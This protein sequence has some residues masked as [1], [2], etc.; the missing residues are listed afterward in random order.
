MRVSSN[1]KAEIM[2][3]FV[4]CRSSVDNNITH[5]T[6]SSYSQLANIGD[7]KGADDGQ[8]NVKS[9]RKRTPPFKII[10]KYCNQNNY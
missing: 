8:R 1:L 2:E 6:R 4:I 10:R 5:G 9:N 3:T 7:Q